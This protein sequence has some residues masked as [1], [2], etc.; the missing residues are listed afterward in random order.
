M[1]DKVTIFK[2][3]DIVLIIIAFLQKSS[4]IS[5]YLSIFIFCSL[6]IRFTLIFKPFWLLGSLLGYFFFLDLDL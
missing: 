5:C 2:D 6:F 3:K 1:K 4:D